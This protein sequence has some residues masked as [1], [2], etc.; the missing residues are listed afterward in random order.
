MCPATRLGGPQAPRK[1]PVATCP[2]ALQSCAPNDRLSSERLSRR[3]VVPVADPPGASTGRFAGLLA[4]LEALSSRIELLR[5]QPP[6]PGST[7]RRPLRGVARFRFP[8]RQATVVRAAERRHG[9]GRR[10][11]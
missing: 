10:R 1:A 3:L 9:E 6:L 11:R 2:R 5:A 4:F 8:A 7:L